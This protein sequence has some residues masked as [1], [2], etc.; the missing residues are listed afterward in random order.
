MQMDKISCITKGVKKYIQTLYAFSNKQGL[1]AT[2]TILD[3]IWSYLKY[4]CV[5]NQYV[6]GCFYKRKYFERKNM[7]TYKRWCDIVKR[8][9]HTDDTKILQNKVEFNKYFKDF[10]KRN[11]INPQV[12]TFEEFDDFMRGNSEVIIKPL[13]GWEGVGVR[14]WKMG[15]SNGV[16][17]LF[18]QLHTKSLLVEQKIAQHEDMEFNNK[19]V[20]TIRVYT[21]CGK[22]S[23]KAQV[24][25]ATLRIGVGESIVDNSHNGGC[26]YEI[27]LE[28][29]IVCSRGWGQRYR[30]N[31]IHPLSNRAVMGFKI[32]FWQEVINM[33]S[34]AAELIPAVQFIGW[35]VAITQDGPLLIE[36]N[37]DPDLDMIEFV[38]SY[39]YYKKI[40]HLLEH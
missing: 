20:N 5:L 10:I 24:F 26:A 2:Y 27:D 23:K 19:S 28:T 25:K 21:A 22:N 18:N 17:Q 4:G 29:G 9:N 37:H 31:I 8:Y 38:G 14:A 16:R 12:V 39:G 13:D 7:L 34:F 11:W 33:C 6:D 36:G 35:D 40:I 3:G 1:N 32:P 30:D 15:D